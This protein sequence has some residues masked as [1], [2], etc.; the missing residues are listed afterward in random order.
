MPPTNAARGGKTV[1]AQ[2]RPIA[3]APRSIELLVGGWE[4]DGYWDTDMLQ[5]HT[6]IDCGYTHYLPQPDPPP[7]EPKR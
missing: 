1:I 3:E 7:Q 5:K 6:A 4:E 2:W